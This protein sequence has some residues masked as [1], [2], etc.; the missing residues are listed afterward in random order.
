MRN[1]KKKRT[2]LHMAARM[3]AVAA[4]GGALAACSNVKPINYTAIHEIPDGPGLFS[5]KDGEF[6]LYGHD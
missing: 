5:G 3:L 2:L 1:W 4:F 6:D